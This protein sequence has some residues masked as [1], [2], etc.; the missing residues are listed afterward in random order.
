ME[1]ED[2]GATIFT[3]FGE[4]GGVYNHNWVSDGGALCDFECA[5]EDCGVTYYKF[6][7]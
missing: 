7:N 2:C 1:C 3:D 4:C 6:N 5:E